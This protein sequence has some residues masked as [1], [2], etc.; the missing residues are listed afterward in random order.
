MYSRNG[1]AAGG[2]QRV[3]RLPAIPRPPVGDKWGQ[4]EGPPLGQVTTVPAPGNGR[5]SGAAQVRVLPEVV[6]S[7]VTRGSREL[8]IRE[9]LEWLQR[10]WCPLP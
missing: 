10:G 9:T 7:F 3:L 4:E 8:K 5:S 1:G 2:Q 6:E